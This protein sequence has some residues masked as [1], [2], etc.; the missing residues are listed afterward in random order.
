MLCSFL[1][2]KASG[3]FALTGALS[4]AWQGSSDEKGTRVGGGVGGGSSEMSIDTTCFRLPDS[5][6]FVTRDSSRYIARHDAH[7]AAADSIWGTARPSRR[8]WI[9]DSVRF[10]APAPES[11][12]GPSWKCLRTI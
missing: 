4:L 8:I 12:G 9:A 11:L 7:F 1:P 2:R 6:R 10:K 3:L 5:S